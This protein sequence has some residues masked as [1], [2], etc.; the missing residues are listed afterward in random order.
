MIVRAKRP[1]TGL[2]R[3]MTKDELAAAELPTGR[4]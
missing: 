3:L 4:R 1:Q 2:I